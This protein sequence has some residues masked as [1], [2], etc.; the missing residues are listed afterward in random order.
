[1]S[2]LSNMVV[3]AVCVC[4]FFGLTGVVIDDTG[5]NVNNS[6]FINEANKL[7]SCIE[8]VNSCNPSSLKDNEIV[9]LFERTKG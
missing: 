5:I 4:A 9:N 1:M 3:G 7:G 8:S 6:I 2:V